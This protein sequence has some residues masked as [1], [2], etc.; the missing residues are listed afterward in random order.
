MLIVP[1]DRGQVDR[2]LGLAPGCLEV[3]RVPVLADQRGGCDALGHHR[4]PDRRRAVGQKVIA[5]VQGRGN[6]ERWRVEKGPDRGAHLVRRLD[7]ASHGDVGQVQVAA[8][9]AEGDPVSV[10]VVG[11]DV[12]VPQSGPGGRVPQDLGPGGERLF[13]GDQRP[14]RHAAERDLQVVAHQDDVLDRAV[15]VERGT[16]YMLPDRAADAVGGSDAARVQIPQRVHGA[17]GEV[18]IDGPDDGVDRLAQRNEVVYQGVGLG[19]AV[20]LVQTPLVEQDQRRR[21]AGGGPGIHTADAQ[22][23]ERRRAR[24]H[25]R[26]RRDLD[27]EVVGPAAV[28]A[29]AAGDQDVIPAVAADQAVAGLGGGA[30]VGRGKVPGAGEIPSA[31][32]VPGASKV[33]GTGKVPSAG[34][35]PGADAFYVALSSDRFGVLQ[36]AHAPG[37]GDLGQLGEVPEK[38]QVIVRA[39]LVQRQGDHGRGGEIDAVPVLVL[40][41]ADPGIDGSVGLQRVCQPGVVVGLVRVVQLDVL[42][43]HGGDRVLGGRGELHRTDKA[44]PQQVQVARVQR[45]RRAGLDTDDRVREGEATVLF[46]KADDDGRWGAPQVL[47]AERGVHAFGT[48]H[49][50]QVGCGGHLGP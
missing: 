32:K 3:V 30:R 19:Y 28:V 49:P 29:V 50:G 37:L 25:S 45:V 39:Q 21:R 42:V 31:C 48:H 20:S 41:V 24:R 7:Q 35:I 1:V 17:D 12:A 44:A 27:L 43:G 8:F 2:S 4:V 40:G 18:L 6:H 13:V 11:E 38:E 33:P 9:P 10:K 15:R 5:G 16:D 36:F 22:V 47:D 34:E 46:V 26:E 14:V 23:G